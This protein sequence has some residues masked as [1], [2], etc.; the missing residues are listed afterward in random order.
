MRNFT[1][2]FIFKVQNKSNFEM[3]I[4]Q[5]GITECLGLANIEF[6]IFKPIEQA[7]I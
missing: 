6:V 1:N 2:Y 7:F 5:L 4:N 3:A